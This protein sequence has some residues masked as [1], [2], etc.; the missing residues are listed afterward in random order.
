[1]ESQL[2]PYSYSFYFLIC[3]YLQFPALEDWRNLVSSFFSF[4]LSFVYLFFIL[5]LFDQRFIKFNIFA[6]FSIYSLFLSTYLSFLLLSFFLFHF[7]V[8]FIFYCLY[9]LFIYYLQYLLVVSFSLT[10]GFAQHILY[11][12]PF[13]FCFLYLFY[14]IVLVFLKR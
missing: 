14:S 7:L 5:L 11:H 8:I 4:L 2:H 10:N 6:S 1:M 3:C 12:F 13:Y 9:A